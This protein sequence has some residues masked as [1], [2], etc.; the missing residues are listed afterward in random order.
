VGTAME[1]PLDTIMAT[2]GK[3]LMIQVTDYLIQEMTDAIVKEMK[4]R[5]MIQ[6]ACHGNMVSIEIDQNAYRL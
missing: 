1:S 3:I 2:H 6:L 4:P 5:K